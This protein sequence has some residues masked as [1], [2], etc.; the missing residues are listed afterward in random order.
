MRKHLFSAF[1]AVALLALAPIA[2]QAQSS[3]PLGFPQTTLSL[4]GG[5]LGFGPELGLRYPEHPVGLRLSYNTFSI[6]QDFRERGTAFS[7]RARTSTFGL[8]ADAYPFNTG[9]RLSA[10]VRIG[11][12]DIRVHSKSA[13]ALRIGDNT[14]SASDL[15]QVDGRVS[16]SNV[17]PYLGLGYT[18]TFANDRLSISFDAGATYLGTPDVSLRASGPL[19]GIA[20][21]DIE[22]ERIKVG[23]RFNDYR[24]YPVVQVTL[25]YRF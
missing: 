19:A 3:A 13:T 2:A 17:A 8:T 18:T 22:R 15:G 10:G 14:Y 25:G 5:T 23:D 4:S 6:D 1:A 9:F 12:T 20:A 21:A 24:F 16:Y 11:D 7:G